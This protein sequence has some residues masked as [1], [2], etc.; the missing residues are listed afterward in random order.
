MIPLADDVPVR[1]FPGVNMGLIVANFAVFLVYELPNQ[2]A[3]TDW[4]FYPCVHRALPQS[5]GPGAAR[6]LPRPDHGVGVPR[7]L[8]PLPAHRG[9]LRTA[10]PRLGRGCR[11]LRAR[12]RIR[13][14]RPRH[15]GHGPSPPGPSGE[16]RAQECTRLT[17]DALIGS[18]SERVPARCR[19]GVL[20]SRRRRGS[21]R[22]GRRRARVPRSRYA[23]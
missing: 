10:Q 23:E 16:D 22:P 4:S 12:G 20:D 2:D 5:R 13:L 15:A 9:E 11:L 21:G 14:R 18:V 8:V 7:H 3:V 17:L 1:R 19:V 6:H